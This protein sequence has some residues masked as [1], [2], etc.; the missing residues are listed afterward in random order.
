MQ[1]HRGL[2]DREPSNPF[3]DIECRD[4]AIRQIAGNPD[5]SSL[6]KHLATSQDG[7]LQAT[8]FSMTPNSNPSQTTV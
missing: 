3:I 7:T 4:T 1:E 2:D 8:S 5:I 6:L